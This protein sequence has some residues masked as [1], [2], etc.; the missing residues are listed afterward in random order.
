MRGSEKLGNEAGGLHDKCGD[1]GKPVEAE[2]ASNL[3]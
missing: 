1:T 2:C 3:E